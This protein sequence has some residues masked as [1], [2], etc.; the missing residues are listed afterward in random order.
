M[1][2]RT[3]MTRADKEALGAEPGDPSVDVL[4]DEKKKEQLERA[5][6]QRLHTL[7]HAVRLHKRLGTLLEKIPVN[8]RSPGQVAHDVNAQLRELVPLFETSGIVTASM[9]QQDIDALRLSLLVIPEGKSSVDIVREG[10]QKLEKALNAIRSAAKIAPEDRDI[11]SAN[12]LENKVG[13]LRRTRGIERGIGRLQTEWRARG[14]KAPKNAAEAAAVLK[15]FIE[16]SAEVLTIASQGDPKEVK[17][18][19]D[20]LLAELQKVSSLREAYVLTREKLQGVHDLVLENLSGDHVREQQLLQGVLDEEEQWHQRAQHP[21]KEAK[22][23]WDAAYKQAREEA[24]AAIDAHKSAPTTAEDTVDVDAAVATETVDGDSAIVED[25]PVMEEIPEEVKVETRPSADLAEKTRRL[26]EWDTLTRQFASAQMFLLNPEFATDADISQA[27]RARTVNDIVRRALITSEH[28][29]VSTADLD[30]LRGL[31]VKDTDV[32][33]KT[34]QKQLH[35]IEK[36]LQQL[37]GRSLN[38]LKVTV[39]EEQRTQEALDVARVSA[40]VEEVVE[41]PAALDAIEPV[42]EQTFAQYWEELQEED[43]SYANALGMDGALNLWE[44]TAGAVDAESTE[45]PLDSDP[46]EHAENTSDVLPWS[47]EDVTEEVDQIGAKQLEN[48]WEGREVFGPVE[49]PVS[50]PIRSEPKEE[51]VNME[52]TLDV[53]P[54]EE[55]LYIGSPDDAPEVLSENVVQAF[56]SLFKKRYGESAPDGVVVTR[57]ERRGQMV[58]SGAR[59]DYISNEKLSYKSD[60][61]RVVI[62]KDG[63]SFMVIDAMGG[64]GN[65]DIVADVL[66]AHV[67][68]G[69]DEDLYQSI[70]AAQRELLN[71]QRDYKIDARSGACFA[72]GELTLQGDDVVLETMHMGD[73]RLVV[74]GADGTVR[75]VS[76]DFSHVQDLVDNGIIEADRAL[77]HPDRNKVTS[78]VSADCVPKKDGLIYDRETK[79]IIAAVQD[80]VDR[81]LKPE[82]ATALLEKAW[83]E[84]QKGLHMTDAIGRATIVLQEGDEVFALTDGYTDNFTTEE[85]L[86]L[87]DTHDGDLQILDILTTARVEAYEKGNVGSSVYR[88]VHPTFEDGYKTLPKDDDRGLMRLK[89]RNLSDLKGYLKQMKRKTGTPQP[90]GS[91]SDPNPQTELPVLYTGERD[92]ETEI[93][94]PT[95]IHDRERDR[96]TDVIDVEEEDGLEKG[97]EMRQLP[98]PPPDVFDLHEAARGGRD[99]E[100]MVALDAARRAAMEEE[101]EEEEAGE[102][103]AAA[104]VLAAAAAARARAGDGGG[105][106]GSPPGLG[107]RALDAFSGSWGSLLADTALINWG[108]GLLKWGTNLPGRA[109]DVG[110]EILDRIQDFFHGLSFSWLPFSSKKTF[111]DRGKLA[112]TAKEKDDFDASKKKAA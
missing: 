77:Y 91:P 99:A 31:L 20:Q 65:G 62:S 19:V 78:A 96:F 33:G 83:E 110:D 21:G 28:T 46:L 7:L 109:M 95:S 18:F 22:V 1:A 36:A 12:H 2:K 13:L 86:D 66:A 112:M 88:Q 45:E 37:R 5:Q 69:E 27:D 34:W 108:G 39:E 29:G 79:R 17:V 64:M 94:P 71:M 41:E 25:V 107:R 16:S 76:R 103:L 57:G 75:F 48:I 63:C 10:H 9:S 92:E 101:E 26:K 8:K 30:M 104:A 32:N 67:A 60:E 82:T 73:V 97:R 70:V 47:D 98:P 35:T 43:S 49:R 72:S 11:V 111:K 74:R 56:E 23:A 15:P 81:G 24:R 42:T 52:D 38:Q 40:P 68:A 51:E 14:P 58:V 3:K 55:T 50:G 53:P 85:L 89:V 93:L 87:L 84:M 105:G 44:E 6:D 102:G 4:S 61:D 100:R 59:L 90:N 54:V 80:L 106:A